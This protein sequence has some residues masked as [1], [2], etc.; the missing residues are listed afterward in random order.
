MSGETHYIHNIHMNYVATLGQ[1]QEPVFS[2]ISVKLKGMRRDLFYLNPEPGFHVRWTQSSWNAVKCSVLQWHNPNY[3]S[4]CQ[5]PCSNSVSIWS[6]N[7]SF[8]CFG[9]LDWWFRDFAVVVTSHALR[10]HMRW[11]PFLLSRCWFSADTKQE[12]L[13]WMEKLGQ[14]LLDFHTWSRTSATKAESRH[15]DAS[16]GGSLRES[17][18]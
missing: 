4:G 11:P 14:A 17:I 15:S 1:W 3:K 6:Q 5:Q 8:L 7:F 13:D 2:V 12:R 16:S 10:D 9:L 18:L